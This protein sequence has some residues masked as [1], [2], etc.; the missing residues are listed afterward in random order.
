LRDEADDALV[1]SRFEVDAVGCTA[2]SPNDFVAEEVAA[3]DVGHHHLA[4]GGESLL[5]VDR[6][7]GTLDCHDEG[8]V[9]GECWYGRSSEDETDGNQ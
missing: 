9:G 8:V 7:G 3:V 2:R 5:A 1:A 6:R 4:F